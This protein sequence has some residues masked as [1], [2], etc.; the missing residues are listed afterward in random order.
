MNILKIICLGAFSTTLLSGCVTTPVY[1]PYPIIVQQTETIRL[2]TIESLHYFP[3]NPPSSG[4]GF[5]TGAALGAVAGS[6]I[7]NGNGSI[8]GAILGAVAGSQIGQSIEN[9]NNMIPGVEITVRLDNNN[10]IKIIQPNDTALWVGQR[11]QVISN[12]WQT[13]VV[14]G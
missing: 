14:N 7:G 13:R 8:I 1:T 11:V 5:S 10:Y 6:Q 3:I 9:Q 12:Q 2:G 4:L